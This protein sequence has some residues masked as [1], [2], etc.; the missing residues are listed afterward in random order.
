MITAHNITP[1]LAHTWAPSALWSFSG[2]S[3]DCEQYTLFPLLTAH[4]CQVAVIVTFLEEKS[5]GNNVVE[6][7][8][9]LVQEAFPNPQLTT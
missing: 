1:K 4:S 5:A 9:E 8:I 2:V 6:S 7:E 3:H